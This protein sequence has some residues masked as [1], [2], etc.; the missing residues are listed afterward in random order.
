MAGACQ[1]FALDPVVP[2]T[3]TD[4]NDVGGGLAGRSASPGALPQVTSA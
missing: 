3:D 4:S 2:T 1:T